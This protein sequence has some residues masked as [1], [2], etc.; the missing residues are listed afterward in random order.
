MIAASDAIQQRREQA[1]RQASTARAAAADSGIKGFSV[2]SLINE[3]SGAASRDV[4][5]IEQNRDWAAGQIGNQMRGMRSQAQSQINSMSPGI[6]P[7]P[8]G[9][10]F[11]IGA[12]G[13][14]SYAGT[15]DKS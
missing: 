6:K 14:N 7:S 12:A 8:W 3:V 5:T 13:V 4:S 9:S 15:L 2:D 11:R 1:M 10:A